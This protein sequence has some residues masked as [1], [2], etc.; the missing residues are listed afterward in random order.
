MDYA[1]EAQ[2]KINQR[3]LFRLLRFANPYNLSLLTIPSRLLIILLQSNKHYQVRPKA[4]TPA[5]YPNQY[6]HERTL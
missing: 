1:Q 2:P 6:Y 5:E 4:A 3:S